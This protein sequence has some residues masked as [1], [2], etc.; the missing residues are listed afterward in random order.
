[1]LNFI[2]YRGKLPPNTLLIP[3]GLEGGLDH[4]KVFCELDVL[5]VL[6]CDWHPR[7]KVIKQF[8]Y[9]SDSSYVKPT[10]SPNI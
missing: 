10:V 3:K 1:M 6:C 7:V 5:T 8:F 2:L 9:W 4:E